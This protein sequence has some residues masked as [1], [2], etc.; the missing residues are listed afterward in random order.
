MKEEWRKVVGFED[1]YE[2]SNLGRVRSLPRVWF[3]SPQKKHNGDEGRKY[4]Y[5]KKGQLLKPGIASTGYP[6]VV[7]GRKAGTKNVHQ[8]VAEAFIGPC[9]EGMEVRHKDGGRT[10]SNADNLHY[11]SRL[12]NINDSKINGGFYAR[13]KKLMKLSSFDLAYIQYLHIGRGVSFTELAAQ[14][15]VCWSTIRRA[16]SND[17]AYLRGF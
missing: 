14:Y 2:V 1:S 12:E 6:S 5:S 3:Q 10:N 15:D 4:A 7:L 11:G 9:P 13:Y 17:Y 8:L 16:V